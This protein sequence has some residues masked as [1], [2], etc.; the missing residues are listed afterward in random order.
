MIEI[1]K[2][3]THKEATRSVI[4]K[5]HNINN[6]PT[7]K[8]IAR[9]QYVA[10]NLFEP[11]RLYWDSP[12]FINSFYRNSEVNKIVK[13]SKYSIHIYGGAIDI[14]ADIF[15]GMTNAELF[16]YVFYNLNFTEL[17]YEYPVDNDKNCSWVHIALIRGR[18]NDK[19]VKIKRSGK[20]TVIF[21][22]LKE[23]PNTH[24]ELKLLA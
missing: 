3:I 2:H 23:L 11:L 5:N 16:W 14:D 10:V 7:K 19:K 13:G 20:L 18:E 6:E 9:M 12:I 24:P 21:D 8:E 15:G 17:I 4:A 1:S 22:P